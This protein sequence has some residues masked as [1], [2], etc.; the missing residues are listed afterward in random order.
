ME[1]WDVVVLGD[2]TAGLSAAAEAA[3]AGAS[4]LLL[5]STSL[6]D[7]GHEGRDGISAS[8]HET[9]EDIVKTL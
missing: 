8:M 4:T 9:T 6:G 7:H 5:S 1:A 2:T 3:S